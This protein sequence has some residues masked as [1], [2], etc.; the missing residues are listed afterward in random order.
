[1][2][3]RL[4]PRHAD[5]AAYK[6]MMGIQ[7][8]V[9][10]SGLEPLLQGLVRLRASQVNGCAYCID[11]HRKDARAIGVTEQRIYALD[12]WRET[13][14]YSD[15]ERAAL[16]WTEA[17]TRIGDAHVS[18]A[19]YEEVR[20]QFDGQPEREAQQARQEGLAP[21]GVPVIVQAPVAGSPFDAGD[22]PRSLVLAPL[23]DFVYTAN[24]NGT[25]STVSGFHVDPSTGALTALTGSPFALAVSHYIGIYSGYGDSLFV[26]TGDSVVGYLIS[27]TTGSLNASPD[28]SAATGVNAYSV[29]IDQA[30]A[31]LYV[32]NNGAA[33][34]SAFQIDDVSLTLT[35]IPG[36]PFPAGNNPVF[37]AIL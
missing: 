33:S 32:A 30:H 15:R 31:H 6:A 36:S 20:Q 16:A 28:Y 7:I 17:V 2:T 11:M 21:Q 35:E 19:V 22:N 29:T 24:L 5:P 4:D 27:P 3:A 13:P 12:A 26:T 8:Y 9:N 10:Q 1:M 18:D 25:N 14:F 23:G 37:M 34:V